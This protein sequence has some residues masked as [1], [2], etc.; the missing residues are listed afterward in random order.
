LLDTFSRAVAAGQLDEDV[1]MALLGD[2]LLD[3]IR[4]FE[5]ARR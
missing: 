1:A 4:V 3:L 5:G 2:V